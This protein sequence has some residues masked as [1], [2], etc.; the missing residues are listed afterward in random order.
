MP[1]QKSKFIGFMLALFSGPICFF[2]VRK[3]KKALMLFPLL[4]V[5][6]VN[7]VVYL[8]SIFAIVSEVR[9]HNRDVQGIARFGFAVCSCQNYSRPGCKFCSSCGTKLVKSCNECNH[10]VGKNERYCDNCGHAFGR[11]GKMKFSIKKLLAF[12]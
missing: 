11:L 6:F 4:L 10:L 1:K 12:G 3:R 8:Y 2:Y 9:Q 7:V 5:P